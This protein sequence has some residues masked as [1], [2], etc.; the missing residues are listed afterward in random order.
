[1][2]SMLIYSCK[3]DEMEL[4]QGITKDVIAYQSDESLNIM[5]VD[6]L[7]ELQINAYENIDVAYVDITIEHGLQ[8]AKEIRS[9]F[10]KAEIMIIS[11]NTISPM[12]YL[13][14]DVKAASLLLKPLTYHMA[15][16]GIRELLESWSSRE[17]D[18]REYFSFEDEKEKRRIPYSQILYFE[19]KN[20]RVY[21]RVQSKEY[22]IYGALDTLEEELPKQFR[23]CHRSY[24]INTSYISKVWYSKNSILLKND[25]EMPLS[26]S[27]KTIIKE[28]VNSEN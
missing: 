3:Q 5:K 23:R 19:A 28:A 15:E 20:R 9:G 7:E 24:I 27:Y 6:V 21:I 14:P 2:I 4:L 25:E 8:A 16:K 17:L 1:M 11:D 18:C 12:M 10:P 13:T 22:G 26:R